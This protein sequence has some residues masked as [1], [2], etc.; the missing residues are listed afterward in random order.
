MDNTT[1]ILTMIGI[2]S[3]LVLLIAFQKQI[4]FVIK[5]LFRGVFGIAGYYILN[6]FLSLFGIQL[7]VNFISFAIVGFLG[8]WGF[9]SLIIAQLIL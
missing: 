2:V 3:F 6:V 4:S 1:I 8:I 5:F 7:G 9:F